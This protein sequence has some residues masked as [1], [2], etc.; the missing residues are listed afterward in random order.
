MIESP[1]GVIL[2]YSLRCFFIN[3][4]GSKFMDI[5]LHKQATA[6]PEILGEIQPATL[7]S[8]TDSKL[9]RQHGVATATTRR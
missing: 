1:V 8:I 2:S 9:A 7:S 4:S 3:S 5:K 6:T